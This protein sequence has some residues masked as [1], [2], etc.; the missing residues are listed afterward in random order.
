MHEVEKKEQVMM[1]R[2]GEWLFL[3]FVSKEWRKAYGAEREAEEMTVH[4]F[5]AKRKGGERDDEFLYVT[6]I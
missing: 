4:I 5:C 3:P 2:D 1:T 6:I